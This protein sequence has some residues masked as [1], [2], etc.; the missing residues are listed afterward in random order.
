MTATT[1]PR[2]T[3]AATVLHRGDSGPEVTELQRRLRQVN[4]YGDRI[5]GIFTRS[6]EDAV[7]T[8]QLARGIQGDPLGA[9]GPA[10][11]KS[12]E[13]ETSGPSSSPSPS[14]T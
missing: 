7:R 11:R 12:L 8:Y 9:Y 5:S 3:P 1:T 14:G 13:S 2:T 6:V 10:T 4:L